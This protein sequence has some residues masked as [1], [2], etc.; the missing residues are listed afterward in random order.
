MKLFSTVKTLV[1]SLHCWRVIH[2]PVT[3]ECFRDFNHWAIPLSLPFNEL[4]SWHSKGGLSHLSGSGIASSS[5]PVLSIILTR[6]RMLII[7]K[8]Y[9]RLNANSSWYCNDTEKNIHDSGRVIFRISCLHY[10]FCN[11]ATIC[12]FII[13]WLLQ[14]YNDTHLYV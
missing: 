1:L 6:R 5:I 8:K 11:N 10:M 14:K 4:Y 9:T 3:H 2:F 12:F 13:S 7:G